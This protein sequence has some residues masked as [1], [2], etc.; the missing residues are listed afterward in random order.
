MIKDI[1]YLLSFCTFQYS[2]RPILQLPLTKNALYFGDY[3]LI[4]IDFIIEQDCPSFLSFISNPLQ[5]HILHEFFI[6]T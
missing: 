5:F 1:L 6:F 3:A 2:K 4:I